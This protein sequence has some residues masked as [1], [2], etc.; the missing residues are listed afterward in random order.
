[1]LTVSINV[2]GNETELARLDGLEFR[3]R[4]LTPVWPLVLKALQG[5]FARAFASEGA[6]TGA[7]WAPLKLSTQRDRRRKGFPPAHPILQRTGTLM[8]ALVLGEGSSVVTT[9][10]SMRYTVGEEARYFAYHRRGGGRLPRRNPVLLTDA[11]RAAA[12]IPIRVYVTR[13]AAP[14]VP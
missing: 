6:S 14:G 11:D 2:G 3:A 9:P 5:S 7:P 13:G 10:T 4:D 8:R 1:M 12:V